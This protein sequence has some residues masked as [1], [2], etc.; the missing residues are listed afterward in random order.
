MTGGSPAASLPS[1]ETQAALVAR[2][3]DSGRLGDRLLCAFEDG[4]AAFPLIGWQPFGETAFAVI[5]GESRPVLLLSIPTGAVLSVEITS[6]DSGQTLH[7]CEAEAP[8]R[9]RCFAA[10]ARFADL[11]A[12]VAWS[13]TLPGHLE[14]SLY[15]T[16]APGPPVEVWEDEGA[17]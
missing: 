8:A 17:L 1:E 5:R 12:G 15:C 3:R 2:R 6:S 14:A 9:P 13:V 11:S 7:L 10:T 4:W 16:Y